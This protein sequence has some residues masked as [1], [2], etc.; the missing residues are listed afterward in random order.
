MEGRDTLNLP[1][2]LPDCLSIL[3]LLLSWPLM[4]VVLWKIGEMLL[5]ERVGVV[6]GD[7]SGGDEDEGDLS[8]SDLGWEELLGVWGSGL[9]SFWL[10]FSAN[11]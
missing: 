5:G 9:C 6:G 3:G 2:S 7:L 11:N 10:F 1:S 8:C 4:V